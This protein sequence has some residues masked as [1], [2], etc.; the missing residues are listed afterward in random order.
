MYIYM[1]MLYLILIRGE[2]RIIAKLLDCTY[3]LISVLFIGIIS[4][5]IATNKNAIEILHL[6]K[7]ILLALSGGL[8]GNSYLKILGT[9]CH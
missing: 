4:C 3:K 6:R 1:R 7:K 9:D 2:R 8:A 5:T